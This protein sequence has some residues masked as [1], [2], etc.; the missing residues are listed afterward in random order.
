MLDRTVLG[1]VAVATAM[2]TGAWWLSRSAPVEAQGPPGFG[3]PLAASD[4]AK[5]A[6]SEGRV[7]ISVLP[8][9]NHQQVVVLDAERGGMAVY[10]VDSGSGQ[11]SLRSVR[12]IYWDLEVAAFNTGDPQ[13]REIRDNILIQ[14]KP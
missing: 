14:R 1:A 8:M 12:N 10:H 5:P 4:S 7:H 6:S 11:I 2:V 3:A 13:P 9:G